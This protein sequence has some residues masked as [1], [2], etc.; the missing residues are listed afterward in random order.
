MSVSNRLALPFID[1]AQAQKHVTH[2]E[3]LA[4]L[5]ALV[6][7]SAIARDV[8]APPADPNEGDRYLVG[9]GASGAFAGHTNS[10]AAFDDGGWSFLA[11]RAGWRVHVASENLL[12]LHD[13]AAWMDAGLSVREV[14]N[15]TRL[16]VG[17]EAD[18]S[19]PLAAKLN[20]ALLAARAA[21]EG[22]TGDMRLALNKSA[23]SNTVSQIYQTNYSGRAET[24]LAGDDRFR[25]KVS[26]DG[27]SWTEALSVDPATG[28]VSLPHTAGVANG[29]ATLDAAGKVPAAQLPA[30]AAAAPGPQGPPGPVVSGVGVKLN[31][32]GWA[33]LTLDASGNFVSGVDRAG[34][35]RAN[36]V[37][38]G[39]NAKPQVAT[40]APASENFDKQIRDSAG[41]FAGGFH[42]HHGPVGRYTNQALTPRPY[43]GDAA[44][45]LNWAVDA[46]VLWYVPVIGQSLAAGYSDLAGDHP[47]A[48]AQSSCDP[49]YAF[50]VGAKTW[51]NGADVSCGLSPL[52]EAVNGASRQT[53][54]WSFAKAVSARLLAAT[55]ARPRIAMS[56]AAMTGQPY[57]TLM[58][59]GASGVYNEA[60]RLYRAAVEQAHRQ[61][62]RVVCPAAIFI[63]GHSDAGVTRRDQRRRDL[64]QLQ[65]NLTED[66]LAINAQPAPIR[67]LTDQAEYVT[68]NAGVT[69]DIAQAALDLHD[70]SHLIRCAGPIYDLEHS[71]THLS[72]LGTHRLG[73]RY[74]DLF[75]QDVCGLAHGGPL[76]AVEYGFSSAAT[77]DV[78]FSTS[79]TIDTSGAVISTAGL[80][81]CGFDYVEAFGAAPA[82]ASVAPVASVSDTLRVTLAAAPTGRRPRLFLACR[83]T[84]GNAGPTSG[85]R[86]NIRSTSPYATSS[87]D[88]SPLYHWAC[89]QVMELA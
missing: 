6:H 49:G 43:T 81:N 87:A 71:S 25:L 57:A 42:R 30:V 61:G 29:L 39:A 78:R 55:G 38:L 85:P 70:R 76:Y 58:R 60:L 4:A 84:A 62:W 63:Q 15:L 28:A 10:I 36:D 18:A 13:G 51:P 11:P 72:A 74:A 33:R 82:I 50:M 66:F 68:L 67:L 83:A 54:C 41:A 77:I 44:T 40:R 8:A 86:S 34:I 46:N 23:P 14:Q 16:G 19:N 56:V 88:S 7:L 24:G 12:L 64:E 45:F 65:A 22:G 20:G 47:T 27:A 52:I 2:N 69:S 48:A 53:I 73:E 89:A 31:V 5:D 3:A 79:V 35:S 59:G 17:A 32:D 21:N 26:A 9:A 80:S 37:T 1:A 75:L